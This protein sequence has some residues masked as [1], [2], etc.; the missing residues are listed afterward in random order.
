MAAAVAWCKVTD[1]VR[2]RRSFSVLLGLSISC[3]RFVSHFKY[4]LVSWKKIKPHSQ[5]THTFVVHAWV[6]RAWTC[7]IPGTFDRILGESITPATTPAVTRGSRT[8]TSSRSYTPLY[9]YRRAV[10]VRHAHTLPYTDDVYCSATTAVDNPIALRICYQIVF[11]CLN[12]KPLC[13]FGCGRMN[14]FPRMYVV[15]GT[16]LPQTTTKGRPGPGLRI[17]GATTSLR[18]WHYRSPQRGLNDEGLNDEGLIDDMLQCSRHWRS[19]TSFSSVSK[20]RAS[21]YYGAILCSWRAFLGQVATESRG[22]FV[23]LCAGVPM[24]ARWIAFSVADGQKIRN[25]FG[26]VRELHAVPFPSQWL[27]NGQKQR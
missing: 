27:T 14:R 8:Q 6:D 13:V 7:I 3:F 25:N 11:F 24:S 20:P 10:G 16:A 5:P 21:W 18:T 17:R 4:Y 12:L 19:R 26:V 9:S 22:D 15:V 2:G 23:R 1:I